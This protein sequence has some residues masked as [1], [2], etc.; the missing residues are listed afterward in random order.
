MQKNVCKKTESNAK[1][2]AT[3]N[4]I[5]NHAQPSLGGAKDQNFRAPFPLPLL[6][7]PH[8]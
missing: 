6:L 4:D 8:E 3:S 1:S 2:V 7:S 5:T